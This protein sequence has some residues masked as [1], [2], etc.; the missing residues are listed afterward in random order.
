MTV[1]ELIEKLVECNPDAR[2]KIETWTTDR[3]CDRMA[4]KISSSDEAVVIHDYYEGIRY[5]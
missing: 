4:C 2:V 3:P 5:D 1:K